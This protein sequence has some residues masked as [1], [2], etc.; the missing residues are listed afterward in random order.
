MLP[1]KRRADPEKNEEKK[2]PI[3]KQPM[4]STALNSTQLSVWE[5]MHRARATSPSVWDKY[6]C[7]PANFDENM[8]T[9]KDFRAMCQKQGEL[10][11]QNCLLWLEKNKMVL[12]LELRLQALRDGLQMLIWPKDRDQQVQDECLTYAKTVWYH[13]EEQLIQY[14]KMPNLPMLPD[15][16][17]CV[18]SPGLDSPP[19]E[20]IFRVLQVT[21]SE[22]QQVRHQFVEAKVPP[23]FKE[24]NTLWYKDGC[25]I[26]PKTKFGKYSS[27]LSAKK[28]QNK[29]K[30]QQQQQ[31]NLSLSNKLVLLQ[32]SCVAHT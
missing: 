21:Q 28:K 15:G 24:A 14:M 3:Q 1:A 9:Y 30:Q 23:L 22:W 26:F 10:H 4:Q 29:N 20:D 17:A 8:V 32:M 6:Q 18:P 27:K 5:A 19:K 25:L 31:E 13:Y 12:R 11:R 2:K 7:D 16:N